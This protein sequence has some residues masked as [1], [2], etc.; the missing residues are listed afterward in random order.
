L[1]AVGERNKV[2][3]ESENRKKK[4]MEL[5]NLL[6]EKKNELERYSVELESLQK[7]E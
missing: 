1:R 4:M 2:E 7:V 3:S 6:N 5:N